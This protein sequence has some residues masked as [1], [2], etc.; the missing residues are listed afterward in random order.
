MNTDQQETA[1]PAGRMLLIA[2]AF[3]I[4]M[5]GLRQAQP[6][7]TPF[8]LAAFL[9]IIC[10]PPL[11]WL[12]NK[13]V[14]GWL[15]LLIVIGVSAFG[16]S[17]VVALAG[18]SLNE[19]SQRIPEYQA[20]LESQRDA[21]VRW[22][23]HYSIN[24]SEMIDQRGFDPKGLLNLAS[25]VVGMLGSLSGDLVLVLLIF[26]FLLVEASA[27]PAKLQA[28]PGY[29][30]SDDARL[31]QILGDIRHYLA[32]KTQVSLLTGTLVTLGLVFLG[33]DFPLLWGLL[34]FF[35]NFVP[36]IGSVIAAIPAVALALLQLGPM[37]A[38][39]TGIGYLVINALIG[40]FLEPRLM[41]RGLGLSTLVV[42]LS[43]IFWGWVLG[44]VGMLLSVPLT[45]MARI[46]LD[47]SDETRWIAILLAAQP[48][49]ESDK[50]EPAPA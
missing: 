49:L 48:P 3:V 46:A 27:L 4:V 9:A 11:A 43:L 47:R 21:L 2:A 19:F 50:N 6:I 18:S 40:N 17:L 37:S 29:S 20:G 30:I 15:A 33:V 23:E 39:Y 36:N 10:F 41:G 22:L 38:L 45:M 24:V 31:G 26:I 7:V 12:H 32:I 25:R 5:A 28:M 1:S 16:V 13:G 44:P 42:F 14:P 35:F 34:A 8:L